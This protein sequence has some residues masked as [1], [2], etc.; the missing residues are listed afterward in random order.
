MTMF[1]EPKPWKI[2]LW[3]RYIRI[4]RKVGE[5]K[6]DKLF[7]EA[8]LNDSDMFLQLN[9]SSSLTTRIKDILKTGVVLDKSYLEEQYL[10]IT[11][12]RLSPISELVIKAFDDG[13][14]RLI[15]NNKVHLTTAMP[16]ITLQ[17]EGKMVACIF[18]ADFSSMNKEG[19]MLSIEMKKLYTLMEAAYI[20]LKYFTNPALFNRSSRIAKV[21]ASIYAE[22]GLRILNRE[23]ALSLDK[24]AF[25]TVNYLLA[26][27]CLSKVLPLNSPEVIHSYAVSCCKAPA[28]ITMQL[29]SDMY[30]RAEITSCEDLVKCIASNFPKMAKL[31]F[32][33]YFERWISS[34]GMGTTLAIDSFPYL[35]YTIINV[36]LGSFLVNVTGLSEIVKNTSGITQ[37]YAEISRVC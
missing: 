26:R 37:F 11:K 18:I 10:Q 4:L 17:M 14:I 2:D 13:E 33:Y 27:F 28:Q 32:R 20:E 21:S 19:T 16:F 35:Y 31:T 23:F 15:Y 8:S 29:A 3:N 1:F 6:M 9:K 12:T 24:D 36:L 7:T 22:M 30:E 5:S 25:D 34:F